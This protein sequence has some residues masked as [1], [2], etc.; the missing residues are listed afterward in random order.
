[1]S[2]TE[3]SHEEGKE[4]TLG[5][6]FMHQKEINF[7]SGTSVLI[8]TG[9]TVSVFRNKELQRNITKS[10]S[11]LHAHTN[12]GFRTQFCKVISRFFQGMV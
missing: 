7:L 6:N 10:D 5:L 12:A 8:N 3:T 1:M 4:D 2:G 11:S 9:L